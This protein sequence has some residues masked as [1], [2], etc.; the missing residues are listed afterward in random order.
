MKKIRALLQKPLVFLA[1][2]VAFSVVCVYPSFRWSVDIPSKKIA[3]IALDDTSA[4]GKATN[5][6]KYQYLEEFL[7]KDLCDKG[8]PGFKLR[9]F[10]FKNEDLKRLHQIYDSIAQDPNIAL[11]VD[12]THGVHLT[13]AQRIIREHN[14][15]VIALTADRNANRVLR[16]YADFQG[17]AVFLK[18]SDNWPKYFHQFIRQ[19]QHYK[20]TIGFISEYDYKLDTVYEDLFGEY[21]LQD[22]AGDVGEGAEKEEN[23]MSQFTEKNTHW[24]KERLFHDIRTYNKR[25]FLF[26]VHDDNLKHFKNEDGKTLPWLPD[27]ACSVFGLDMSQ[28][29][30]RA[31]AVKAPRTKFYRL[32]TE[33]E[34]F[35]LELEERFDA[36]KKARFQVEAE[37]PRFRQDFQNIAEA[38]SLILG[39]MDDKTLFKI[40]SIPDTILRKHRRDER[41]YFSYLFRQKDQLKVFGKGKLFQFDS[42]QILLKPPTFSYFLGDQERICPHQITPQDSST[43]PSLHVVIGQVDIKDIDVRHNLFNCN[44]KY[45]IAAPKDYLDK[46]ESDSYINFNLAQTKDS[47]TELISSDTIY[48]DAVQVIRMFELSGQMFYKYNTRNFPFDDQAINIPI[49]ALGPSNKIRITFDASRI[50]NPMPGADEELHVNGWHWPHD[51]AHMAASLESFYVREFK[52]L[53]PIASGSEP[54]QEEYQTLGIR[55]N[56]VRDR[57]GAWLMVVLPLLIFGLIPTILVTQTR[58]E[59]R[60]AAIREQIISIV[61]TVALFGYNLVSIA[62]E[63][64]GLN[65]AFIMLALAF[66]SNLNCYLFALVMG[67]FHVWKQE[68]RVWARQLKRYFPIVWRTVFVLLYLS[69]LKYPSWVFPEA[70]GFLYNI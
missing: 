11:V 64:D 62:P 39:L 36:F 23:L 20:D 16:E 8:L 70:N 54:K 35:S 21:N 58:E 65:R 32:S 69:L 1:S 55:V 51:K 63:T 28:P 61:I 25:V 19:V 31:M 52:S 27:D 2:V 14:I 44:M 33:P 13:S 49:S 60:Y 18:P 56:V 10:S 59:A 47:K 48:N 45:W 67:R 26:S 40:S 6:L 34:K 3:F 66:F 29:E 7:Q 42:D 15:P 5:R 9:Y 57:W 17:N 53:D 43:I 41:A 38:E 37:N 22:L 46:K 68:H 12:N 24:D 50:D 4:L 30:F